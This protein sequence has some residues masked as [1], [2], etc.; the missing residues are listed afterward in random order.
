[1][2]DDALETQTAHAIAMHD[3]YGDLVLTES[4]VEPGMFYLTAIQGDEPTPVAEAPSDIAP[5]L[6]AAFNILPD[7]MAEIAALKEQIEYER[8]HP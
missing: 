2:T 8:R 7:L 1:M 3:F 5:A 6:V 4:Q